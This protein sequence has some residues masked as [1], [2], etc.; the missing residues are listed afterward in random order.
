ME[1]IFLLMG[2]G[3]PGPQYK[4]TRHNLGFMI[5][6]KIS[7]ILKTNFTS[8]KGEYLIARSQVKDKQV[9]LAKP[10]TYMNR[11]GEAALDLVEKYEI[12]LHNF[13]VIVDDFNLPFGKIR[14]R[15]KGSD[16][17][18]NGL[19]DI[20][21]K[22]NSEEFPRLRVG[23]GTENMDDPVRFVLSPF[24]KEELEI[25]PEIIQRAAEGSIYFIENGIEKTMSKYN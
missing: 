25:L 2:L 6:E 22:L 24:T 17:G 19:A 9:F 3:N 20:I 4:F 23:I 14:F 15:K 16:G 21:Y 11:S 13:L 12:P 1:N 10:L 18:H 5:V 7:D 8:G